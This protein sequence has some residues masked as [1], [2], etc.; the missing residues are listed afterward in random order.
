M[1]RYICRFSDLDRSFSRHADPEE[2]DCARTRRLAAKLFRVVRPTLAAQPRRENLY[3]AIDAVAWAAAMIL[4]RAE[5][6]DAFDFFT[7]ALT[8][9]LALVESS[10]IAS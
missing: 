7:L 4:A 1:P 8:Q 6:R 9:K 5:D 3:I 10:E 2:V